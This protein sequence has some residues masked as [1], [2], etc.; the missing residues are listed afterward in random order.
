MAFDWVVLRGEDS[1]VKNVL[2][3]V[4]VIHVSAAAGEAEETAACMYI[5]YCGLGMGGEIMCFSSVTDCQNKVHTVLE[6]HSYTAGPGRA[7]AI[8]WNVRAGVLCDKITT[9]CEFMCL[10]PLVFK[11]L[12]KQLVGNWSGHTW[13]QQNVIHFAL[14][15]FSSWIEADRGYSLHRLRISAG[16]KAEKQ[17]F[18]W[19]DP[20]GD[21][22][23]DPWYHSTPLAHG[24]ARVLGGKCR[25]ERATA[26]FAPAALAAGS[27][28][29]C[30]SPW[31]AHRSRGEN[32]K[33]VINTPSDTARDSQ[34]K[35]PNVCIPFPIWTETIWLRTNS[36]VRL[37]SKSLCVHNS[38][39]HFGCGVLRASMSH[40]ANV[41]STTLIISWRVW[42]TANIRMAGVEM[43]RL[44]NME[45]KYAS[46]RSAGSVCVCVCGYVCVR[47]GEGHL[48]SAKQFLTEQCLS[49]PFPSNSNQAESKQLLCSSILQL[50]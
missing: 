45:W 27:W 33:P 47:A 29:C 7:V 16:E 22:Y 10:W 3:C 4:W 39:C 6:L 34:A 44:R 14:C 21:L 18:Q 19:A 23:Q 24:P 32:T 49:R 11:R 12:R 50:R 48:E 31:T 35:H 5:H 42:H 28:L 43:S 1:F 17:A 2:N 20:G 36:A 46:G 25:P 15:S 38:G 40:I 9:G 41:R 26:I 30:S 8:C 13:I 37:D